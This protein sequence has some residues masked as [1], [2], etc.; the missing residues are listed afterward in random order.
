MAEMLRGLSSQANK[1]QLS[2]MAQMLVGRVLGDALLGDNSLTYDAESATAKATVSG[3]VSTPWKME[4]GRFRTVLD[5]TIADLTFEPNR[6]RPA[7]NDIPVATA[8][9]AMGNILRFRV[10]LPADGKG[11]VLEGDQT[12]PATLA[13]A[14][15]S[16]KVT[17]ADGWLT[18]E[19]RVDFD[20]REIAPA[21]LPAARAQ[22]A[23]AK[24]RLLEAVAP[25]DYPPRWK[26]VAQA[27][28]AQAFAPIM[29]A[30]ASAIA[31]QQPGDTL[32]YTNRAS[33][34]AGIWDWKGAI[35][36]LDKAIETVPSAGLYFWRA[37]LRT[38]IGDDAGAIADAEAGLALEP[39]SMAG[40]NQL[41]NLKFRAGQRDAALAMV[42]ER[43]AAGGKERLGFISLQASL[44][45]EAGRV[46]EGVAA[47]DEAIRVSPGTEALLNSR[48]WLKGTLNVALD[49][50]LKDCTRAIEIAENPAAIYDSRAMVY[51]RMGRMDDA[52]ADLD[53]ALDVAPGQSASLYLRGVVR[54]RMGN[55]HAGDED[56]AAARLMSPRID[57]DYGRY[58]IKP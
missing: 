49:T 35:A 7:W 25:A 24:T 14:A 40:I 17:L 1:E 11:F 23:L 9:M 45:G 57:E 48:C 30:Y 58:G 52:L 13:G 34:L 54:R 2:G 42:A 3:I 6:A 37:Q 20:G 46:D 55:R 43:I 10:H 19:D 41:A 39:G 47:L 26:I 28:R 8:P 22:V 21:E 29:A 15:V 12:L 32:G 31:D 56:L 38:N 36:D 53:A 4:G 50:A 44:L 5:K 16:R 33:F 27:D 51:F 18:V